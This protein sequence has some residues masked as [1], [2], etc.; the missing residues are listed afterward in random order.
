MFGAAITL[1][2]CCSCQLE[3]LEVSV[4][5]EDPDISD[6]ADMWGLTLRGPMVSGGGPGGGDIR[7]RGRDVASSEFSHVDQLSLTGSSPH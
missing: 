6:T 2:H 4:S 1:L 3:V 5:V 7:L